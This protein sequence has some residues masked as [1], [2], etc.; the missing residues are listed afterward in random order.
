MMKIENQSL[1]A[2]I[3]ANRHKGSYILILRLTVNKT[4]PVGRLGD[5]NFPAAYYAYVGSAFGPGGLGGRIGHHL[6]QSSKPRWHI[7]YL[8]K[9]AQ[10][11][12]IWIAE[13]SERHEHAWASALRTM[14]SVV[15]HIK[16][17]GSSDCT[18]A[19]HLF[20]FKNRPSIQDFRKWIQKK[21]P[22]KGQIRKIT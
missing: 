21:I 2:K 3:S 15:D 13:H 6:K 14:E 4:I 1:S 20:C 11:E 7:D 22:Q 10:I 9:E 18:C 17:F 16:G 8:R 19:T 5:I 12:E